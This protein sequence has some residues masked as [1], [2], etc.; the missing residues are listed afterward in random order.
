MLY[1][2]NYFQ[3]IEDLYQSKLNYVGV[4]IGLTLIGLA[5]HLSLVKHIRDENRLFFKILKI[6]K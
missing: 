1:L 6:Y 2:D 3:F 4:M 5:L